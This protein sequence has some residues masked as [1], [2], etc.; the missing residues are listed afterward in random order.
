MGFGNKCP[1]TGCGQASNLLY[2]FNLIYFS[3]INLTLM[4]CYAN[5]T[6]HLLSYTEKSG[7]ID[8]NVIYIF[9][10]RVREELAFN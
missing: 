8:Y 2:E 5:D 7:F 9:D 10:P 6:L 1:T 4:T 3:D